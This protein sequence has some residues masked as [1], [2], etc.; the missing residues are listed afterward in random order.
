M[1]ITATKTKNKVLL[2]ILKSNFLMPITSKT[3]S[4]IN[5]GDPRATENGEFC[6]PVSWNTLKGR[7]LPVKKFFIFWLFKVILTKLIFKI[8][9]SIFE[10]VVYWILNSSIFLISPCSRHSQLLQLL[11]SSAKNLPEELF[12]MK[13][14][15]S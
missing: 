8:R 1:T 10:S 2:V 5:A 7:M 11:P 9:Y 13:L 3:D 15:L 14:Y 6:S 12:Y 4:T